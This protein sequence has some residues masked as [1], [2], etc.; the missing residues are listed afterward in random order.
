[1]LHSVPTTYSS[2]PQIL[3]SLLEAH[4]GHEVRTDGDSMTLAFHDAV[5]AVRW[6]VAAQDALLAHPWPRRLLEHPYCAPVTL[7]RRRV[8][9]L[10]V[11]ALRKVGAAA[12]RRSWC[13]QP[14]CMHA[15]AACMSMQG[16]TLRRHMHT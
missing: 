16:L 15:R 12:G 1:M 13:T 5:D 6:A 4:G 8:C 10:P 11:C 9:V 7:V 2:Q 3:R 14:P